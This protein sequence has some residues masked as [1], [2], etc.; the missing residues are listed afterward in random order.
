MENSNMIKMVN[1]LLR[2]MARVSLSI[3]TITK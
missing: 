3:R 2:K 1:L